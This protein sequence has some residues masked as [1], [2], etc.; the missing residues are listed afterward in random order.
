MSKLI[1]IA[2]IQ[3]ISTLLFFSGAVSKAQEVDPFYTKLLEKGEQTFLSG[4]YAKAIKELEIA[5][6][7]I[8]GDKPLKARTC[9]YLGLC[10][11]YLKNVEKGKEYLREAESLVGR[12]GMLA[13]NIHEGAR[14]DLGRLLIALD[15]GGSVDPE[16]LNRLPPVP[17]E[18]GE[19]RQNRD[20]KQLEREIKADPR[21][22]A[23]YY[24]LYSIHRDGNNFEDAKETIENLVDKNPQELYGFFLLG[25]IHYQAREYEDSF[26]CLKRFFDLAGKQ[27]TR[28]ELRTEARAYHI[29]ARYLNGDR[30]EAVQLLRQSRELVTLENVWRL[31]LS[32]KDK[33]IL[34]G[35]LEKNQS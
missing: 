4:D 10:H 7:G 28:P 17:R 33:I 22:A 21:N 23:L 3:F 35:L 25:I 11:Y 16:G 26:E 14:F 24:E 1:R 13:F 18:R 12:E 9:T 32:D 30:K 27:E 20:L 2:A 8:H 6:F 31:S 15:S 19:L 5:Y 29:L 34:R